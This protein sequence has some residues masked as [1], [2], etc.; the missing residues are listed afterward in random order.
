[1]KNYNLNVTEVRDP[2][3]KNAFSG[4]FNFTVGILGSF[5]TRA[6]TDPFFLEICTG[7]DV[8]I[9][10]FFHHAS[11]A[12]L[13]EYCVSLNLQK[14]KLLVVE[15]LV[16]TGLEAKKEYRELISKALLYLYRQ[17]YLTQNDLACGFCVSDMFI[18]PC[19]LTRTRQA[20]VSVKP[21]KSKNLSGCLKSKSEKR[22]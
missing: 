11:D 3:F 2:D 1:M 21:F 4:I 13:L 5:Q 9:R 8:A 6:G 15:R 22:L 20:I 12:D 16:E 18:L 17:E 19:Y 7:L 14:K 10:E